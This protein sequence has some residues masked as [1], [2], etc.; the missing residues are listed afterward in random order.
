MPS[1]RERRK[2]QAVIIIMEFMCLHVVMQRPDEAE[3]CR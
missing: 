2:T 3:K 1:V